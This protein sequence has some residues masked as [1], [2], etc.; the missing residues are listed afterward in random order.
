[1]LDNDID[2]DSFALL[3]KDTIKE[4][5]STVGI[6]LKFQDAF[7][8][9]VPMANNATEPDL[10]A[11]TTSEQSFQISDSN[12]SRLD[13]SVLRDHSK[14][15]GYRRES[16]KLTNWQEA[17]NRSAY[18]VAR[19]NPNLMYNRGELKSLAEEK[20]R[21]TYIFKKSS[22]SRSSKLD[23]ERKPKRLKYSRDERHEKIAS[24]SIEIEMVKK[25]ITTKQ[26]IINKATTLK[27]Y[28][29]CDKTQ[30]EM[31]ELLKENGKL[32]KQLKEFQKKDAK[33][34]WY[35]KKK[36][37]K[38]GDSSPK[39][40]LPPKNDQGM[41]D[42][43]LLFMASTS[44]LTSVTSSATETVKETP[45]SNE[46]SAAI[47]VP[48]GVTEGEET[49]LIPDSGLTELLAHGSQQAAN[50]KIITVEDRDLEIMETALEA[51]DKEAR[52]KDNHLKI[53]TVEDKQDES[54]DDNQLKITV[55][56]KDLE[57]TET[58]CEASDKEARQKDDHLKITTVEDKQDESHDDNQLKIITVPCEM[59]NKFVILT[60]EHRKFQDSDDVTQSFTH[61]NFLF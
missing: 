61:E 53:T 51:N 11:T 37:T 3:D 20:A 46:M 59:S 50:L 39:V 43:R 1:M 42:I 41:K 16:A 26:H 31:R 36:E 30:G 23:D 17:V 4:I 10:P 27:K 38:E 28:E 19:E 9:L 13:E 12:S 34:K 24:L 55:E 48:Y 49:T 2:G 7:N 25:Q 54:H 8:K 57:I 32:E 29:L 6:R 45:T 56:E 18:E 21:E 40:P 5:I 60:E 58:A 15:Y 22:G 14:I 52:Q 35:R 33:S 47:T 44:A